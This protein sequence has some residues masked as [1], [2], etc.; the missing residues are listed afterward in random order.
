MWPP[1]GLC[2]FKVGILLFQFEHFYD[3]LLRVY[4]SIQDT[5]VEKAPRK[6]ST[7][8]ILGT[9]TSLS[10]V[11]STGKKIAVGLFGEFIWNGENE[12]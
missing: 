9:L 12:R 1:T 2:A 5:S 7:F 4:L 6:L 10:A 3:C 11:G 8:D